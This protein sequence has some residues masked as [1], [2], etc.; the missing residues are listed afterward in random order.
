MSSLSR[1]FSIGA[2]AAILSAVPFHAAKAATLAPEVREGIS[3]YNK[4]DYKSAVISFSSA[5]NTEFNNAV[6][7]YYLG[8]CFIKLNQPES[9]IREFR[10]AY[11][12]APDAEVGQYSKEAL[13]VFGI[14]SDASGSAADDPAGA[15]A[16]TKTAPKTNPALDQ[17]I[18]SLRKQTF[19]AKDNEARMNEI[20]SREVQKRNEERLQRAKQEAERNSVRYS[21]KGRAT[22]V[23]MSNESKKM[24]DDL[25]NQFDSE[26]AAR[27]KNMDTRGDE[28]QRSATNLENLLMEQKI[29]K[30]GPKLKPEGTNLYIR[31]YEASNGAASSKEDTVKAGSATKSDQTVR[32]SKVKS[33][34][35]VD[36]EEHTKTKGDN[37]FN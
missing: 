11:A 28:L 8:N 1:L 10:I 35:A 16:K 22:Q 15:S 24:L 7:H 37:P 23:P 32:A 3:A 6:V 18:K 31:N 19:F 4:A 12:I 2:I 29:S 20:T 13:K 27:K 26:L 5:L 21:R 36:A 17:A 25:K 30:P 14:D 34:P 33:K 9:A